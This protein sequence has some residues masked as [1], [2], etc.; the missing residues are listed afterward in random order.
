MLVTIA[1]PVMNGMPWLP[2]AVASVL[3]QAGPVELI[4]CDGGSTD[5]SREWLREHA[6]DATQLVFE[7]DGGQS[8]AIARALDRAG[9]EILGW[10]NADDVL[11]TGALQTVRSAFERN[12]GAAIVSG[13]CE[14]I[15]ERGAVIGRI[16]LPPEGTRR[17]LLRH[18]TNLAQPAT[19]FRAGAFRASGGLDLSLHYAMDVDLWLKLTRHGDAVLLADD[20]LA[21]FR[22]HAAAK[23]SR[24]AVAM[25]RE[26]LRVRLR[27]G[28][29]IGS[30]TAWTL[31][32][33]A[34]VGPLKG[35]AKRAVSRLAGR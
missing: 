34:Y 14:L 28:L 16:P 35:W 7:P 3:R 2:E 21:Q 20:V 18:P 15:D 31:G 32:H 29:P 4:V 19:L 12:P 9:G 33:A 17:G 10:L 24:A 11:C 5:G 23:T 6:G 26:D 1:M 30:R 25:L 27:H 8:E 22:I 13:G